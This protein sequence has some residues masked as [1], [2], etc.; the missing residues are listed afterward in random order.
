VWYKELAE[1]VL[2]TFGVGFRPDGIVLCAAFE[3]DL[4]E[5]PLDH[6]HIGKQGWNAL[7]L[8][9]EHLRTE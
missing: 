1:P 5:I 9:A 6:G 7:A 4:I 8:I 2:S 3:D